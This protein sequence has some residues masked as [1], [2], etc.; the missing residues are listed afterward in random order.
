MIDEV[1]TLWIGRRGGDILFIVLLLGRIRIT[2]GEGC[3][4][5]HSVQIDIGSDGGRLVL[6]KVVQHIHLEDGD[7]HV[8]DVL[9]NEGDIDLLTIG[10]DLLTVVREGENALRLHALQRGLGQVFVL[11]GLVC[12]EAVLFIDQS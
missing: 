9:H 12:V 7:R 3:I 8:L 2:V 6:L 4:A 1:S 10:K 11:D 5:D